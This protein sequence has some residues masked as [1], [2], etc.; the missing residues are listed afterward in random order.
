[1]K[2][3]VQVKEIVEPES[4]KIHRY[5]YNGKPCKRVMVDTRLSKQLAGYVLIEKD[6]RSV[7]VW[8]KEI[9]SIRASEPSV[10]GSVHAINRKT[11]N[12]IK[13]LFVAALTFYGKCFTRC[14]GRPVKLER[15]QVEEKYRLKHDQLQNYR[16][17]FAA[18]SGATDIENVKIAV[19]IPRLKKGYVHPEI[20]SE[21]NQP[22]FFV[23]KSG[24]VDF[25]DVVEN[26]RAVVLKKI[27]L[28]N[29]KIMKEEI[30]PQGLDHW[31]KK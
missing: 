11:Y 13:G 7:I 17:N 26:M 8:L 22:D 29:E 18:H 3:T 25:I 10:S 9:D 16:N 19:I 12:V 24:E 30:L 28:L 1:M 15:K 5:Y 14:E 2:N 21:L 27:Q 20:Y 31:M 6:L 4:G 23:A